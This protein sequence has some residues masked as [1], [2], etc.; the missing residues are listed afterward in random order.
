MHHDSTGNSCRNDGF[1]MSPS[2]GTVQGETNWSECSKNVAIKLPDM[3]FCL[4]D[5]AAVIID[6]ILNHSRFHNLPGREWTA[7][8][9]C[10]LF[11]QDEDAIVATLFNACQSLQCINPHK[12]GYYLAGPALE[13]TSCAD[14]R[15]CRGGQCLPVLNIPG[16]GDF[17]SV[18]GDWS[19]W[20][21]ES[22][23]SCCI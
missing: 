4:L 2:R 7:K 20:K 21:V 22:C 16:T 17:T 10:E 3:K 23:S 1:I 8:K 9:Q 13:G 14:G 15:E 5:D 19:N 6:K 12:A 11:L 18:A